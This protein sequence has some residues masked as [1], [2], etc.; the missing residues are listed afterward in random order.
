MLLLVSS[1]ERQKMFWMCPID[2]SPS[3]NVHITFFFSMD[4]HEQLPVQRV[5]KTEAISSRDNIDP[6]VLASINSLGC[7]HDKEKLVEK[8]LQEE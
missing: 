4:I 7:F 5:V 2:P 8:L 3:T 6:D 1:N